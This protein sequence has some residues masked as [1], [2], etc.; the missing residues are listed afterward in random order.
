[1]AG[2]NLGDI[3]VTFKAKT[4]SLEKGV[5][6]VKS[7]L[8]ATEKNVSGFSAR[9]AAAIGAVAGIAQTVFTKAMDVVSSSI[10][11]AIK[12]VDTLNNST[13]VFENMGFSA[14][15]VDTT[16]KALT[17][18]IQGLPTSLDSAVSNVQLLAASTNDIAKSQKI[19]SSINNAVLG[20][21]GTAD[22]VSNAVVQ[23]SQDFSN[24]RISAQT[25][26]SMI[27]SG[28]GPALNAMAK[29]MG[30]TTGQLK[31]GLSDGT[32]SV[33]KFQQ[34]L[35]DMNEKGGGGMASFEQIAK[36]ATSGIGSGWANMQTAIVRGTAKIIN[37]IGAADISG[38]ISKIGSG[39]ESALGSIAKFITYSIELSKSVWAARDSIV[40]FIK[41]WL[42]L[43]T[44]L[45]GYLV[46][47]KVYDAV[48]ALQVAFEVFRLITLPGVIAS[49]QATWAALMANPILLILAALAALAVL[50]VQHWDTVKKTLKDVGDFAMKTFKDIGDKLTDIGK[51]ALSWFKD[52]IDDLKDAWH[53]VQDEADKVF[54]A[55]GHWLDDNKKKIENISIVIGTILLPKITAIGIEWTVA[56]AKAVAAFAVMSASAVANAAVSSAAWVVAAALTSAAW[57]ASAVTTAY[58]WVTQ[59]LPA[60][61]AAFAT[62]SAQ[63]V[64]NAV[65][66]AAAFILSSVQTLAS[67][68]LTFAGYA[69][70]VGIM[71]AM[72]A[73]A[74]LQLAASWLL[75]MGPLGLL[76]AVI[77]G[78]TALIIANWDLVKQKV[79][80]A[81]DWVTGHIKD[82]FS[83]AVNSVKNMWSGIGNFFG[84]AVDGIA[85]AIGKVK[86]IITSPFKAA[87][88]SISDF[89][90]KTISK[91]SF[92]APDWV[93]GIGGK[94]WSLP[95]MPHLALGTPDWRGGP[96]NMNEFGPETAVLPKGTK[97]IN[98]DDTR[99]QVSNGG[100]DTYNVSLNGV[101]AR[102][103]NELA[104]IMQEGIEALDR[105]RAGVGK[106]AILGGTP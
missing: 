65:K 31:D 91:V 47:I 51:G 43:I 75:A 80:S 27:N 78:L 81:V 24:G 82:A 1:M 2:F 86:D 48:K 71:V 62:M 104:D 41:T 13:R 9:T 105:R 34:S 60:M 4:D 46:I 66:V 10:G 30:L 3:F 58:A 26:L 98:A 49:I 5:T 38:A 12:R 93:P 88:N 59:T 89:W 50:I 16:V 20:F 8:D 52:R 35:I 18:S 90:N 85:G 7:S 87:L 14:G 56:A 68:V 40:A 29:Q 70:G 69:L 19:F 72:T 21:G 77:I 57:V 100:G 73:L 53:A 83:D 15:Q 67:W 6:T 106:P 101:I 61:I 11:S 76:A 99:S 92:K 17:K 95:E 39:F 22:M 44:L 102:S 42:P 37:A 103:G 55:I 33:E 54:A 94:G 32:I 23:M 97:V 84:S 25:W 79:T 36:D 28:L 63:A 45:G 74:A 64:V 96:V